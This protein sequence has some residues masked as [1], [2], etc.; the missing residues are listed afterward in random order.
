[1]SKKVEVKTESI[2]G[3]IV[4]LYPSA[5]LQASV[6]HHRP[7][8]EPHPDDVVRGDAGAK[9]TPWISSSVASDCERGEIELKWRGDEI[10]L[11]GPRAF[12][13]TLGGIISDEENGFGLTTIH[14]VREGPIVFEDDLGWVLGVSAETEGDSVRTWWFDRESLVVAEA[15]TPPIDAWES[16]G[17][18]ADVAAWARSRIDQ[19]KSLCLPESWVRLV[20]AGAMYRMSAGD[21]TESR[22]LVQALLGG[23]AASVRRPDA[24]VM[25]W[26]ERLHHDTAEHYVRVAIASAAEIVFEL[27]DLVGLFAIDEVEGRERLLQLLEAREDVACVLAVARATRDDFI[28]ISNTDS[29]ARRIV[30]ELPV[31]SCARESWRLSLTSRWDVEGWWLG[32]PYGPDED[33]ASG[34]SSAEDDLR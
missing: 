12:V 29:R 33:L 6:E 21:I 7:G 5:R 16:A 30:S 2:P 25:D 4:E 14:A 26:R 15:P 17:G 19:V 10:L 3:R 20:V 13:R 32:H 11:M 27:E 18:S 34:G 24:V 9:V 28:E 23:Q 1:M 8:P 31:V 22:A